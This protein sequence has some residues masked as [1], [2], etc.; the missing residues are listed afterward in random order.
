ME[1][2][3]F[4]VVGDAEDVVFC[5][6]GGAE[7]LRD[8]KCERFDVLTRGRRT[9]GEGKWRET[10]CEGSGGVTGHGPSPA[11]VECCTFLSEN[12][13]DATTTERLRVHLTL[14]FERIKRQQNLKITIINTQIIQR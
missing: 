4:G 5:Y 9:G 10:Y 6:C 8:G 12:P 11:T 14:D 2:G 1:E 3:G 7:E 13:E